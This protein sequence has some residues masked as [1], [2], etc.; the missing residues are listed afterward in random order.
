M[1]QENKNKDTSLGDMT[2]Q[3]Q[4]HDN[5]VDLTWLDISPDDG[6][7]NY[8]SDSERETIPQLQEQWSREISNNP[9]SLV[10]GQ[11]EVV[12]GE[13]N[14]KDKIDDQKVEVIR[15]AKKAMM[16]G[17][18]GK[19]VL[20]HLQERFPSGL[21]NCC[22]PELSKVASETG[23]LGNVYLDLSAFSTTKE[24]RDYL[25]GYKTRLAS[26]AVGKPTKE[27]NFVDSFGKCRNLSK[28]VVDKV[29]YTPG[30][31][32]HYATHLKN[33]GVIASS[34]VIDS[35]EKLQEAFLKVKP[36]KSSSETQEE[37]TP[38][39]Q[40]SDLDF[41]DLVNERKSSKLASEIQIRVAKVRPILAKI[42][43][44]MIKGATG[45]EL[46]NEVKACCDSQTL[47]EF[48]PE[49]SGLVNRQGLVGPVVMDVSYY[50]DVPSAVS[51]VRDAPTKPLFIVG[52]L[53]T[54]EGFIDS[55]STKSGVPIM[56]GPGDFTPKMASILV[57]R[58]HQAGSISTEVA[59]ICQKRALDKKT[60]P[61]AIVKMAYSSRGV[62]QSSRKIANV[63]PSYER[64]AVN[65][66]RSSERENK[67]T[68]LR[69]NASIAL[70]KGCKFNEVQDK[71]ASFMPLVEAHSI[72]KEALSAMD[73]VD[74]DVL[75][76]CQNTK[77]DLKKTASIKCASKCYGCSRNIC[78]SCSK[79][80]RL[81]VASMQ[82]KASVDDGMNDPTREYDLRSP[83]MDIPIDLTGVIT[84]ARIPVGMDIQFN[85][86]S[87]GDIK[88]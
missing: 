61:E 23:L 48:E 37:P 17:L 29:D 42:Q 32:A 55:V 27:A 81:F 70:E 34:D 67:I 44:I 88:F 10:P 80:S 76:N 35:K 13:G 83:S 49:I 62:S 36:A 54:N 5:V 25:G 7:A 51:E 50:S 64:G 31:L 65:I 53:P 4:A 47:S 15:V 87:L 66:D 21:L 8:P 41:S 84:Q 33:I 20:A 3:L 82:K 39:T 86:N 69:K 30:L 28:T 52:T 75:D 72:L 59:S 57:A 26:Y 18:T 38:V 68:G 22:V 19:N 12:K 85:E 56:R 16:S 78:G 9:F 60:S 46:D 63:A 77:Y 43:K 24:A 45:P 2:S 79:Q 71:V 1:T 58:M 14:L 74:A 73:K 40:N 11:K 6:H